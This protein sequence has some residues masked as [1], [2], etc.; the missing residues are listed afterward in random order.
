LFITAVIQVIIV[1]YSGSIALLADTI[2]NFGDA[3]T[4]IPLLFAFMLA[5]WKPS[6]RFTYGFGRVG[7]LAGVFVVLMV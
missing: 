4:A 2:H 7:D 5:G 1:N 3:L 6:K